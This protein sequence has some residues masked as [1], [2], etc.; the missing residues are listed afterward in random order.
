MSEACIEDVLLKLNRL[1]LNREELQISKV[2]EQ[3]GAEVLRLR[4]K[5]EER[6]DEL[7]ARKQIQRLKKELQ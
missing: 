5:G 2:R 4:K 7:I 1:Y 6:Y 3:M